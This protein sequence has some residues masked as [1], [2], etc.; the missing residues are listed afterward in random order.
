MS[1][2]FTKEILFLH[3]PKTGG[4]SVSH[5]LLGVLPRPIHYVRQKPF[6]AKRVNVENLVYIP[7]LSHTELSGAREIVAQHGFDID[8]FPLVLTVIH[9]PYDMAVSHY[10]Y[11]RRP[12][13]PPRKTGPLLQLA[14][15]SSF[16]EFLEGT[17]ERRNL[18][19]MKRFYDYFHL[20]GNRPANL[21]V[22]RFERLAEDVKAALADIGLQSDAPFP[23]LNKSERGTYTSYFDRDAEE[24]VY[25]KAKWVFE[26]GYYD[27]LD[28]E[29]ARENDQEAVSVAGQRER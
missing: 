19:F 29:A 14:R 12:D 22:A 24:L 25:A 17:V 28:V 11:L 18:N 4:A 1:M 2:M 7:G 20:D 26:E 27:R 15:R 21:R 5:Y 10:A 3:V 9:N 6:N 8:A 23:W 13:T 16:K